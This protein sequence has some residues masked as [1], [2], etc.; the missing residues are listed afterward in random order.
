[1]IAGSLRLL[2]VNGIPVEMSSPHGHEPR[3]RSRLYRWL[4]EASEDVRLFVEIHELGHKK[5]LSNA[6]DPKEF[7]FSAETLRVRH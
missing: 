3:S 1:M 7:L 2:P 4:G 5:A 6:D